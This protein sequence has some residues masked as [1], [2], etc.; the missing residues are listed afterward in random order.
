MLLNS[1]HT[2]VNAH[3]CKTI[4]ILLIFLFYTGISIS[5]QHIP[6]V[7]IQISTIEQDRFNI[8]TVLD[9]TAHVEV[10]NTELIIETDQNVQAEP[11]RQRLR[12]NENETTQVKIKI[13]SK[14]RGTH[15]LHFIIRAQAEGFEE[16]GTRERRYLII[17][18]SNP[19][20]L[21][22]GEELRKNYRMEIEG[23][24]DSLKSSNPDSVT[25]LDQFLIGDIQSLS[26][27][28]AV[29]ESKKQALTPPAPGIEPYERTI[30][31][32]KSDEVI[33][34]LDPITVTGRVFYS[35]RNGNLQPFINATI[36]IRD[37]DNGPDEHL[38]STITDWNGQF[39]AVVNNDDGWFQN[40]RDIYVRIRATN[41]RFRVQDCAAWPDWTY[42]WKTGTRSNLS[43]GTV[44]DFGSFSLVNY[45][46][47]AI[48][49]QDLNQGWNFLTA[50][51][52]QDPGFVDLCYPEGSSV[53]STF[54]EEIDI[55]D[56]DE[57]ARDIVLH[58]YGHATMHNAYDDYW[59]SNTGGAHSFNDIIHQNFAFTEGWGTFIALSINDDGV[60]NSNGWSR[61]IESFSHTSGHTANDGQQ[62]EGHVAAGM[63]DVRDTNSDGSCNNG[64]CDE[65][66]PNNA[67]FSS[68][69]RDAF[70][71]S[72]A[73]NISEYWPRL[74]TEL[75]ANQRS[76]A[77]KAL[78][79]N[80]IDL[81][82]CVC[83][84][85]L[86]LRADMHRGIGNRNTDR[87]NREVIRRDVSK[88]QVDSIQVDSIIDA[89][90]D[91]ISNIR[92][93]SN[94]NRVV[95]DLRDFRDLALR[96][97][98]FGQRII[99]LYYMHTAE[100][101]EILISNKQL[102]SLAAVLFGN[103]A[104]SHR[105]LKTGED[106]MIPLQAE[107]ANN[108]HQFLSQLQKYSSDELFN[109]LD[110]TKRLVDK[111]EGLTVEAIRAKL[112]APE[113]KD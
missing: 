5:A 37:S 4:G 57:E 31:K 19:A 15:R 92:Q 48:L 100:I 30:I 8:L 12:F 41:S 66:G 33:K 96:N 58:E 43:D 72:K 69:W 9:I 82:N 107:F 94:A 77:L 54:W 46:E 35:D 3:L 56:G 22:N 103:A 61:L 14:K 88:I 75:N 2:N 81:S 108:I 79:F 13:L 68:I 87:I 7:E 83:T 91:Y 104:E 89:K 105:I 17:D 93:S 113:F 40:G 84:I 26:E 112:S 20:K 97:T 23:E 50:I 44:A 78:N 70:W 36:D 76:V 28:P 67:S 110:R 98:D 27:I 62:N 29:E 1:H 47:S 60:Y 52:N 45:E 65:S 73:D 86:A 90:K 109:D 102:M 106:N 16:A 71:R 38:T 39:S 42:A 85:E 95:T 10:N 18:G 101:S 6:P 11:N 53:Y 32:D 34:E 59:P 51:G 63:G 49:H 64:E 55:E 25:S 111:F 80:D 99:D 74:C 24:I 21:L